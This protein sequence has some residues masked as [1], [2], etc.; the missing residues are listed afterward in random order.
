V[1][2]TYLLRELRRRTRQT[3]IVAVG[4]AVG[5]GLVITVNAASKGV[6][7]AQGQV[8]SSLYGVGTD[9]TVTQAVT[10][11]SGQ[12]P[13][14]GFGQFN[15]GQ[16]DTSSNNVTQDR[17]VV[18]RGTTP[19][20][21]AS[22]ATITRTPHVARA[23]GGLTLSDVT[24]SGDF[25][26]PT[27][28]TNGTG[29]G[30]FQRGGNRPNIG[31]N[32]TSIDGVDV[33]S[34]DIGPLSAATLS[35]GRA[36]TTND[37][38]ANVALLSDSYANEKGLVVGGTI[39]VAG[40]PL[41]VVGTVSSSGGGA[42]DVFIPLGTA[43][44]LAGQA[45]KVTTIY[46]Q[47]SSA[48]AV[49]TAKSEIQ[50][51]LPATT[52]TTASDLANQISGSLSSAANLADNLGRWLSILVLIAAFA[53]A[54]LFT[55]SGVSR[56]TRE[57]GTLKALGWRGRRIIGQVAGEAAVQG[58]L[59]GAAG[60]ALGLIGAHLVSSLAPPLSARI[61]SGLAGNGG[62]GRFGAGGGA[63][64]AAGNVTVHLTAPVTLAAIGLAVGLAIAGG[65]IAGAFGGWRAS[66]LRPADA[67]RRID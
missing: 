2:L 53:V 7:D 49:D 33:N 43:Q 65:L 31:I 66:R 4:L 23:V 60:I 14:G 48:G 28:G 63:F 36:F 59:G 9:I 25:T 41:N 6:A 16:G 12:G 62:N 61:A 18:G 27:A 67:L 58:L 29:T 56:R 8:L 24:V 47:A 40:T 13:G 55:I 44:T 32:Q 64:R 35:G 26:P 20:G 51:A 57:L 11:G 19:M 37:A 50:A 3:L 42:T 21:S 1:F 15:F 54:A 22:I 5:I 38:T 39:T 34:L 30:G 17:L 46:V 10:Q 45:N 52:V